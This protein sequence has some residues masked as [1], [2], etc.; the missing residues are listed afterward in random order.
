MSDHCQIFRSYSQLPPDHEDLLTRAFLIVLRTSPLAQA[1]WVALVDS[2]HRDNGGAGIG[3][4]YDLP[5]ATV[6]TQQTSLTR[7]PTRLVSVLQ[8]TQ[9]ARDVI[10]QD[11]G[12][13]D[14]SQRLDGIVYFGDTLAVAIENKPWDDPNREQLSVNVPPD[15]THDPRVANVLWPTIIDAWSNLLEGSTL[16]PAERLIIDD[17]LMFVDE[18]FPSLRRVRS[19]RDCRQN[20]ERLRVRCESILTATG[21]GQV[22]RDAGGDHY[23]AFGG[24]GVDVGS[25]VA[26]RAMLGAR[27]PEEHLHFHGDGIRLA[28][29]PGDTVGQARLLYSQ[30]SADF[31]QQLERIG[32]EIHS[33]LHLS[34]ITQHLLY[35]T[36]T[37]EGP[38]YWAFWCQ[39]PD[40]IRQYQRTEWLELVDWLIENQ[41]M[42]A[43]ERTEFNTVFTNTQRNSLNL[44]PGLIAF[45][46]WT[47]EEATRLD[48]AQPLD[49][50]TQLADQIKASIQAIARIFKL[51]P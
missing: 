22:Q 34:F 42:H 12:P 51:L 21:L 8:T 3:N 4:F 28:V 19:I 44:C 47:E 7:S 49:T 15:T 16:N 46:G 32:W 35:P 30:Y 9:G 23:L 18:T 29:A 25:L 40:R 36:C 37:L 45:K 31:A 11:V 50:L 24:E 10:T 20:Q 1:A 38:D 43:R 48:D 33:N 41:L 39:H 17:F 13:S 26:L 5:T 6:F 2:A 14:R 27:R